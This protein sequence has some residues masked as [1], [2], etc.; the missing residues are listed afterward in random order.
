MTNALMRPVK[1]AMRRFVIGYSSLITHSLITSLL[2]FAAA[3]AAENA[4]AFREDKLR[5]M[6]AAIVEAIEKG[7]CPGG[8][9][10]LEQRGTAYH[11]AYGS[12]AVEP[13][14]E[15]MTEDTIF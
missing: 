2:I 1:R 9:L 6:D 4:P 13:V 7:E 11:K 5:A 14:R 10:W 12:R 3:P 8:V 15:E